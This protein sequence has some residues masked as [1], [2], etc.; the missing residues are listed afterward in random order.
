MPPIG[1]ICMYT[2]MYT[3]NGIIIYLKKPLYSSS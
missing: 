3:Y 2:Y 1:G